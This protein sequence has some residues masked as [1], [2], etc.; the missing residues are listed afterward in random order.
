M[1]FGI[2]VTNS[3]RYA[4][5]ALLVDLAVE[6]EASGWDG[7]F[8][9]DHLVSGGR[10]PVTDPRTVLAAI[11]ARTSA[12]RLG[13]MVTPLARR[14]PWVV[15]RQ[16]AALDHLS[17]GRAVLG[18][19]LGHFSD[20]EFG[21]FGDESSPRVRGELLDESL[22]ILA[23]LWSG[24]PFG[25]AGEHHRIATTTFRPTPVQQPRIPIWVGGRWPNTAP[26]RR[27]ARWDGAFAIPARS[28]L[29]EALSPESTSEM[30][31]YVAEH[32]C[33]DGPFDYVHAG[34]LTG[35]P[36]TDAAAVQSYGDLGVT[37]WLEQVSASRMSPSKLRTFI[38]RGPPAVAR[39][40]HAEQR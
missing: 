32:R 5:P 20:K 4:D 12:L 28:G 27:A 11:A 40:E 1:R 2:D 37:W 14:R 13:P 34:F 25:F 6:A 31:S 36:E 35:D 19:G 33:A 16:A 38:R 22:E 8:V 18:V 23:G 3:G 26:M 30:I 17:G 9:W 39:A 24:E 7:F 10:S 29:T 21:G 15:A